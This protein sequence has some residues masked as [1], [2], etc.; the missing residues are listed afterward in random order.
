MPTATL[1]SKGQITLPKQV[2]DR[3]GVKPGDR[4]AFR[5]RA[6]GAIVVEAEAAS[7]LDLFGMLKPRKRGVTLEDMEDAIGR[8]AT[9]Q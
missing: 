4:I 8:G 1:T 5:E 6:D 7:L 2:R 3:L 9:G